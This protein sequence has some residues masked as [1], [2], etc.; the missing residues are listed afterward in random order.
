MKNRINGKNNS[1]IHVEWKEEH[2]HPGQSLQSYR[3][4]EKEIINNPRE[5]MMHMPWS[6]V[7]FMWLILWSM[8]TLHFSE[9]RSGGSFLIGNKK[10]KL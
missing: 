4:A 8:G 2:Q 7:I 6:I 5:L 3:Y 1:I 10:N 9:T